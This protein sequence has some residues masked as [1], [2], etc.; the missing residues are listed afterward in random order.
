MFIR[1]LLLFACTLPLQAQEHRLLLSGGASW[2]SNDDVALAHQGAIT[3]LQYHYQ[4]HRHWSLITG[5]FTGELDSGALR[6]LPLLLERRLG[7]R[8]AHTLYLQAGNHWYWHREE[9]GLAL[10]FGGGW[11]WRSDHGGLIRA[12]YQQNSRTGHD[13][14]SDS[15]MVLALGWTF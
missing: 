9:D 4:L 5:Y 10:T 12:G 8:G 11:Q 6:E 1:A 14:F 15:R 3:G 2:Q 13:G 7:L